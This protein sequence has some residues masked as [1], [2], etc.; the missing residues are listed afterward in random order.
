VLVLELESI[1]PTWSP[2]IRMAIFSALVISSVVFCIPDRLSLQF[3]WAHRIFRFSNRLILVSRGKTIF[4]SSVFR[5][6]RPTKDTSVELIIKGIS[7]RLSELFFQLFV[8]RRLKLIFQIYLLFFESSI[9]KVLLW[10]IILLS[11]LVSKFN[12]LLLFLLN[13]YLLFFYPLF[14]FF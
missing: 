10:F 14:F 13:L 7:L 5:F 4:L 11:P 3:H 9:Q 2:W 6:I 1:R 8:S 12:L